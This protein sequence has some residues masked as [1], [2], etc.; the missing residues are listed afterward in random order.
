[1]R[2]VTFVL[3]AFAALACA[4]ALAL[5]SFTSGKL[6]RGEM[7]RGER[8]GATPVDGTI[9]ALRDVPGA[10]PEQ[11]ELT[12]QLGDATERE[13]A[14]EPVCSTFEIGAPVRL[15]RLPDGDTYLPNGTWAS[16]GNADFD[17]MLLGAEHVM[18]A[19]FGVATF[20]LLLASVVLGRRR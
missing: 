4:G 15:A 10:F 1:M 3:A 6:E 7:V 13:W 16:P 8:P 19:V 5:A 9:V 14:N 20:A 12:V 18:A 11:C 17:R 2:A